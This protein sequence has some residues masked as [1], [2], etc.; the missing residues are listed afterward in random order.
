MGIVFFC[1][2]ELPLYV[3]AHF[4]IRV[5]I[6][7]LI[8]CKSLYD[9]DSDPLTAKSWYF[10]PDYKCFIFTKMWLCTYNVIAGTAFTTMR[11]GQHFQFTDEEAYLKWWSD[12]PRV[13]N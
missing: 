2:C 1:F 3:F 9:K 5:P 8:I 7:L 4:P 12:L 11:S 10:C 13:R 6:F